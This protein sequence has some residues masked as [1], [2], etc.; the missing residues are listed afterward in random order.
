M[1][2]MARVLL[3]VLIVGIIFFNKEII[4]FAKY[5]NL[6]Q[7][8]VG[9][10][11]KNGSEL[12][13]LGSYQYSYFSDS[14]HYAFN[15]NKIKINYMDENGQILESKEFN[16][17][18]YTLPLRSSSPPSCDSYIEVPNS[19]GTMD[20]ACTMPLQNDNS[21]YWKVTNIKTVNTYNS[22]GYVEF[23]LSPY[24]YQEPKVSLSCDPD[25]ITYGETSECKVNLNYYS[26]MSS[27]SFKL[28]TED[29]DIDG[30]EPTDDWK[31]LEVGEDGTISLNSTENLTLDKNNSTI[32]SFRISPKENTV[33]DN[34]DNIQL[35]NINYSD[36]V[37]TGNEMPD[38]NTT[39]KQELKEENKEEKPKDGNS[40]NILKNPSTGLMLFYISITLLF[41]VVIVSAGIITYKKN[42]KQSK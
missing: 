23:S 10:V 5:D 37:V 22:N 20:Y 26:Q 1:K 18:S 31:D 41:V 6:N 34:L 27:I 4:S 30:I 7:I 14:I 32:I 40:K 2:K 42:I 15:A 39:V 16:I 25:T 36:N 33:I 9:D 21:K 19:Y 8:K 24:E 38:S 3:V 12:P 28:N 13:L 35:S 11:I 29:Y 17:S